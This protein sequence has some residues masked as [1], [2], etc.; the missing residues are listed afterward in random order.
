MRL[1]VYSFWAVSCLFICACTA[2]G[3]AA[4]S[5]KTFGTVNTSAPLLEDVNGTNYP[6]A[7]APSLIIR[8]GDGEVASGSQV[9]VPFQAYDFN[10]LVGFQYTIR[11]DS[12]KLK[13]ESVENFGLPGYGPPD[14][15]TRFISRGVLASL[16]DDQG[17]EPRS[18]P[19]GHKLF[20]LCFTALGSPGDK[21]MVRLSNGPTPF[22]FINNDLVRH[23][24][25]YANGTVNIE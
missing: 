13:F 8:V 9:C 20:D 4:D 17:L 10:S 23:R 2:D 18:L 19:Q 24:L 21:T 6:G 3:N 22:E 7:S 16:W 1:F 5:G 11:W 12:T 14:F 25:K 15:G